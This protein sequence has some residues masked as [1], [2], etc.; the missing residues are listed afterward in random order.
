MIDILKTEDNCCGKAHE[1][2]EE[3]IS[4]C[5]GRIR[6]IGNR[7]TIVRGIIVTTNKL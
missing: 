7:K 3:T 6:Y 5:S 1:Y 4:V 2:K